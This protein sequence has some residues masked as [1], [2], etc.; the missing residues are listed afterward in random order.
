MLWVCLETNVFRIQ[1]RIFSASSKPKIY[2]LGGPPLSIF[3]IKV[4]VRKKLVK[5]LREK[6][7]L[8]KRGVHPLQLLAI[9]TQKGHKNDILSSPKF[10]N[11]VHK[12]KFRVELCTKVAY[13]IWCL[14]LIIVFFYPAVTW[15]ISITLS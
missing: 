5:T 11:G 8:I 12:A 6:G 10:H 2:W 3:G 7:T 14:A 13:Q 1:V 4:I 9:F 15:D